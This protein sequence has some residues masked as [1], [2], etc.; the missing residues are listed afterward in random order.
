MNVVRSM[1]LLLAIAGC[2]NSPEAIK[3]KQAEAS[4][5]YQAALLKC[6][7]DSK[8]I[9]ESHACEE[10]LDLQWNVVVTVSA[11]DGGK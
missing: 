1:T 4:A 10:N 11:K 9:E 3:A 2:G 8:T 7:A 6:T 5:T